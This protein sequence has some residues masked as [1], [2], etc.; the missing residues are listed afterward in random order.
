MRG[1]S[2]DVAEMKTSVGEVKGSIDKLQSITYELNGTMKGQGERLSNQDKHLNGINEQLKAVQVS[3][4]EASARTATETSDKASERIAGI[5]DG[6]EKRIGES[7]A[8]LAGR[9]EVFERKFEDASDVLVL[10]LALNPGDK[11][12]ARSDTS[13]NYHPPV[14]LSQKPMAM[15]AARNPSKTLLDGVVNFYIGDAALQT[16][17]SRGYGPGDEGRG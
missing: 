12:V 7:N 13:L 2:A 17:G 11:P 14:P 4:R 16:G 6:V 15:R 1:I 9:L 8:A 10:W 5:F 3:V